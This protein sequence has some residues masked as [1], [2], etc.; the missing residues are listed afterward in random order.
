MKLQLN[1]FIR[2]AA[3]LICGTALLACNN[4]D[5]LEQRVDSLESRIQALETQLPALNE[6]V[7]ALSEILESGNISSVNIDE[8]TGEV[9]ITTTGGNT[10]TFTQGS[11]GNAPKLSVDDEGYW[12]VSYDNWETEERILDQDGNPVPATSSSI[13]FGVSDD[14]YWEISYDGGE[15]F[16][17]VYK[18]DGT[19]I[20]ALEEDSDFFKNIVYDKENQTLTLTLS[21]GKEIVINVVSDFLCQIQNVTYGEAETFSA[22]ETRDFTVTMRGV[23]T[24]E[25]TVPSGWKATL[26]DVADETATLSVTAPADGTSA[27][28]KITAD[29]ESDVTI[30]AVSE[31]GLTSMAK[32][33]VALSDAPAV[34]ISAGEA[35]SSTLTFTVTPNSHVTSFKYLLYDQDTAAPT[36]EAAFESA[37]EVTTNLSDPITL[38]RTSGASEANLSALTTYVLYVLPVGEG[39]TYGSIR[40]CE[41]TTADYNTYYERYEAGLDITVA[42]KTYNKNTYGEATL[43]SEDASITSTSGITKVF[44]VDNDATLTYNTT[45][46]PGTEKAVYQLIIIG[47]TPGQRS[48]MLLNSQVAL[49]QGAGNT[50]GTFVAYNLD[51]DAT[52]AG[53]YLFAQN[54]DGAYGYVGFINCHFTMPSGKPF[55]Y[56]S[57]SARS[58]AEFTVEDSEIEIPGTNQLLL[59]S[60]GSS[61]AS[62]GTISLKN[63][64]LYSENG[65]SDF[66]LIS[67]NSCSFSNFVFEN[68]TVVNLWSTTSGCV[69]YS[70]LNTVSV[71]KNLF[72]T[73]R[74]TANMAFFRPVDTSAE[75]G[76]PY[77]GNPTGTLVDDSI[78]YKNGEDTN[79]QWFYGGMNRVNREGFESCNE[80]VVSDT[81]PL[82]TA[83]FE[84]GIFTPGGSYSQYGAQRD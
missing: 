22:G 36:D 73:D 46:A 18:E 3:I 83:D 38:D 23:A 20:P 11:V 4:L 13:V 21:D 27:L 57:S 31:K 19:R 30:T 58:Y 72:W 55:T 12:I 80:I 32:M 60:F 65:V 62:H 64:V 9:T 52:N 15:T 16:V 53:N 54:R 77:A 14:G 50:D 71:T 69:L 39:T 28:T 51:I 42:G 68:N 59:F 17:P 81:D 37:T 35:T 24:A 82:A 26:S 56:V 43:V 40:S 78:V 5:E 25:V 44:F 45:D 2:R 33:T 8:E 7:T 74:T 63:N 67:G 66:R 49:N 48:S 61:T 29:T 75:T 84:N 47:N 76:T 41:A 70:S 1:D 34:S 6:N 79:W 10:Y